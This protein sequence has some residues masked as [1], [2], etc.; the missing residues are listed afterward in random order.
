MS[1]VLRK[2]LPKLKTT[3]QLIKKGDDELFQLQIHRKFFG[4]TIE[5]EPSLEFTEK[6]LSGKK[7]KSIIT[8]QN[9]TV[10]HTQQCGD[11]S[12]ITTRSF[13]DEEMVETIKCGETTCTSW[14][15]SV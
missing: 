6:T 8:F 4:Q 14:Y 10:T 12:I 3:V 13:F 11:M 5:F 7:V 1:V 2:L 15:A 9:N